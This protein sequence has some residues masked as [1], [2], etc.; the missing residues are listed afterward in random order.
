MVDVRNGAMHVGTSEQSRHVLLDCLTLAH[1][2]LRSLG[3]DP[4]AFYG[5]HSSAVEVLLDEKRSEVSYRVAAKRARARRRL[6]ELEEQLGKT[7][8]AEA[9]DRLEKQTGEDYQPRDFGIGHLW[10]ALQTCPECGMSARL[11]GEV[12]ATEQADYDVEPM[13]GGQYEAV[14]IGT[15]WDVVFTPQAF[16]CNVCRLELLGSDEL[17]EVGLPSAR[18]DI[19]PERLPDYDFDTDP[20]FED[21][22]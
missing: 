7:G 10:G 22:I 16:A 6:T 18:F 9:T 15:Y 13:G 4:R 2:L 17:I 20:G 5:E 1:E 11:Y 19:E 12:E 8:F 21:S 3:E 14:F